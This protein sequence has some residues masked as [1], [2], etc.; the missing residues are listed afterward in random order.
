MSDKLNETFQKHLKLL[1]EHLNINEAYGDP[2]HLDWA[3]RDQGERPDW[4]PDGVTGIRQP[5]SYRDRFTISDY[6]KKVDWDDSMIQTYIYWLNNIWNNGKGSGWSR[7]STY[8]GTGDSH[9]FHNWM[10][11]NAEEF[12]AKKEKEF[13]DQVERMSDE[14][15][16]P[17]GAVIKS[18]GLIAWQKY[19]RKN[20]RE[21]IRDLYF[22]AHNN[23]EKIKKE[24]GNEELYDTLI[25]YID[26]AKFAEI[27]HDEYNQKK[28]TEIMNRTIEKA[29]KMLGRGFFEQ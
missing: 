11:K 18:L 20:N 16:V 26:D 14:L 1:H 8:N 25:K 27:R 28:Y 3:M 12:S 5:S 13:E 22:Q 17:M 6:A 7:S 15:K 10:K 9:E 19:K 2:A 4:D 23:K 21:K 24:I 29:E